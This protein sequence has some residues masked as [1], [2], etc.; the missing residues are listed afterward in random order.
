MRHSSI[1]ISRVFI[2][3]SFASMAACATVA[4]PAEEPTPQ[5]HEPTQKITSS[6]Q[7]IRE[8]HDKYAGNWYRSLR[9]AQTNTFYGQSG[10]ETKSRWVE[11]LSVPGRL[12]IDFEPLSSKSG[13]LILNNRVTTFDNG[14]RVDSRRAIQPI[15]TLT[16][17]V[18]AIPAAVTLRRLDSLRIDLNK[19]RSDRLDK[20]RVYVVGADEGDLES[21]QVWIDAEKLLLVRLIQQEKRGDRTIVTDTRVGGYRD[22]DGYPV[23][24]E[25][26]SMR[27]GKPYFKEEYEDV[28]VN[29]E[30]P[31]GIFDPSKWASVR[32]D[33]TTD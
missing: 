32:P 27:D 5:R 29:A 16:A 14:K 28:R 26:M 18:Y 25:F 15:L 19:F 4:P 21:S 31:A 9:F 24:H 7:L 6:E 20:K 22:L 13:L 17:D 1:G 23:A 2:A 3:L 10:R 30:L 12:R 11:N 33:A 8:M